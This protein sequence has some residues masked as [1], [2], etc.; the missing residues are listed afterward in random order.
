MCLYVVSAPSAPVI[1]SLQP[2]SPTS[3]EI[4]WMA[5]QETDMVDYVTIEYMYIGPCNCSDLQPDMCQWSGINNT[6]T[7]SNLQEHSRYLF[8]VTANNPAGLSSSA[9]MNVTTLSTSKHYT[10]IMI[11]HSIHQ[12]LLSSQWSTRVL[13]HSS[14]QLDNN[15]Y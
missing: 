1:E 3:V 4:V 12:F 6:S 8:K 2:L 9:K 14:I 7:I 11:Y 5:G 10:N 15:Y 13:G